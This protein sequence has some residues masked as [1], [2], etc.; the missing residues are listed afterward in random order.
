MINPEIKDVFDR[1]FLDKEFTNKKKL[2][3]LSEAVRKNIKPKMSIHFGFTHYRAHGAAFELLRQFKDKNPE[4]TLMATGVLEYG[5]ILINYGLIKKVIASF[6]GD[7]YPTSAPNPILQKAFSDKSVELENWTNLTIPLR[8][9]AAA[10]NFPFMPTNSIIGSSIEKE[11]KGQLEI[12]S[13]PNNADKKIC[14]LSPLQPD[15]AIVHGLAADADGNTILAP[16]YGENL[17]GAFAAKKGVIITVEKIVSSEFIRR[18]SH[19][20][21]IPGQIVKTVSEVPFGAFPQGMSNQGVEEIDSY[22]EDHQFRIDFRNVSRDPKDFD[23]WA[24]FWILKNKDHGEFLNKIGY[25]RLMSLKGK[26]DKNAWVYEIN[27]KAPKI[28]FAKKY[29]N[30]ELMAIITARIIGE[31]TKKHKYKRILGGIGLSSLASSISYYMIK[32]RSKEN[33]ELLAETGFYG[34]IPRPGDPFVFN[35]ANIPTN[36]IQSNFIGVL[37]LFVSGINNRCLGVLATAQIDKTGNLNSTRLANGR[38]LVGSGGANDICNGAEEVIIVSKNDKR[39][40]VNEL[41]YITS[42]GNKVSTLVTDLGIFE[43]RDKNFVLTRYV[44]TDGNQKIE[45]HIKE[46][47]ENTGWEIE[48][49]ENIERIDP[50]TQEEIEIIRM[51]DP[52]GYFTK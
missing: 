42:N 34:Y 19:L 4:F 28:D 45:D 35:F 50:P 49:S 41:P 33:I 48:I 18:Y 8:F 39:R 32:N 43:K 22:G 16:P 5:I 47:S 2:M 12:L 24:D 3:P 30:S 9:M 27:S 40:L 11:N 6:Y 51:L 29:S 26:A 17:W 1:Y 23:E 10:Y 21:K 25:E 38:Y 36:K 20:V 52:E 31:K 37:N 15:I 14:L 13:R 46:I 44:D 7:S